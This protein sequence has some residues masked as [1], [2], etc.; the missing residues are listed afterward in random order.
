MGS[1]HF[2]P[3]VFQAF[4]KTIGIYPIGTL[5]R[6]SCGRLGVVT[7]QGSHSLLRP[8]VKVFFSTRS[9]ERILPTVIDL[10]HADAAYKI[11]NIEDPEKWKFSNLSAIW[12]GL[13]NLPG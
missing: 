9:N 4:V 3:R 12:S 5:V 11:V 1:R 8:Q 7:E 2:E 13:P 10:A 6:L